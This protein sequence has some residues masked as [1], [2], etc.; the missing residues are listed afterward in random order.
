MNYR[1][2]T[3]ERKL[4]RVCGLVFQSG[5][6]KHGLFLCS[7]DMLIDISFE[8]WISIRKCA[9]YL[10]RWLEGHVAPPPN[11]NLE[12]KAF[13]LQFRCVI[14]E[15]CHW[16]TPPNR[17]LNYASRCKFAYT[18]SKIPSFELCVTRMIIQIAY[19]A[20][21]WKYSVILYTPYISRV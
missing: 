4:C 8:I 18:W 1:V 15:M 13:T 10:R 16:K 17:H 2:Y 11:H 9:V 19:L 12:V 14:W 20:L 6:K 5:E 3:R 21:G 7:S